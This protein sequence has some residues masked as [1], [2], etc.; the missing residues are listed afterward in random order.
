MNGRGADQAS[1]SVPLG[2]KVWFKLVLVTALSILL[3]VAATVIVLTEIDRPADLNPSFLVL[4]LA[5]IAVAE[6]IAVVF[7]RALTGPLDALLRGIRIVGGGSLEYRI[8]VRSRDELGIVSRSFNGIVGGF[9][10]RVRALEESE[11]RYRIVTES[12]NDIIFTLDE[13]GIILFLNGRVESML[14][15]GLNEII[16]K[17]FSDFV[18][19]PEMGTDAPEYSA[20]K[21]VKPRHSI[22]AEVQLRTKSGVELI[23]EC[24]AVSVKEPTGETRIHGVA[25]DVT[26]RKSM[27]E[28]L[29]KTER[30]SALGEIVSGVAHELRN[31]V[32]G[33]TA[34]M[35]TLRMRGLD[36]ADKDLDRVLEEALR[37]QRIVNNLLDFS[38]DRAT[39]FHP[40]SPNAVIEDALELC[41]DTV[42]SAE[43]LTVK[44]L[45]P[46]VP[47]VLANEEQLRQVFLNIISNAIQ[48]MQGIGVESAPQGLHGSVDRAWENIKEAFTPRHVLPST[49][50]RLKVST[51]LR[52][53]MAVCTVSDTGPGI[54]KKLLSRV[55]D[56]FFTTKSKG[57]G[58]GLGLS[59]SLGIVKAHGGDIE[60]ANTEG[61]GA[62]FSVILPALGARDSGR[63]PEPPEEPNLQ[64]K[65]ILVV[66]DEDSIRDFIC[67]FLQG[68]GCAVAGARDVR[69]AISSLTDGA[70]LDLVISDFRMPDIDGQGLYD[71]IRTNRPSLLDKIIYITGD[72][73]NPLT[74]AFLARTGVPYM[75]KPVATPSLIRTV[76]PMLFGTA[77]EA[78]LKSGT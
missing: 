29:R 22:T 3:A 6:G 7:V 32:M 68:Y 43:I 27:H 48:A 69:E 76:W 72:G 8:P 58:T 13:R 5:V 4:I 15:Y 24:E 23:L 26:E 9:Q 75:L 62:R 64:G 77:G 59:V 73:L 70:P 40:C 35:Q 12:V 78:P 10:D 60:A 66:E 57:E 39:A 28:R 16:G 36:N 34:S 21:T 25:R 42:Q 17:R 55:F 74:R 18:T 2:Q 65:R 1:F 50:G 67:N 47:D 49:R 19:L 41:R 54:P 30:L 56:P 61:G 31:A 71:W 14:G 38:P 33:I 53:G 46:D 37:A 20:G 44:D 45:D 63:I 51:R 11:R 52:E